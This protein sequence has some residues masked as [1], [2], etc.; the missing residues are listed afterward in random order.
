MAH[1]DLA[2]DKIGDL[3]NAY[4]T[5]LIWQFFHG[6]GDATLTASD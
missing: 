6:V 2:I 1:V 4:M 5:K 3:S